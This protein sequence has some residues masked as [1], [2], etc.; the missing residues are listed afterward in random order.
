MVTLCYALQKSNQILYQYQSIQTFDKREK[1][2]FILEFM[3]FTY[4]YVRTQHT[5]VHVLPVWIRL[6]IVY[7]TGKK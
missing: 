3:R 5:L 7:T 2:W 1:K 6:A 4:M